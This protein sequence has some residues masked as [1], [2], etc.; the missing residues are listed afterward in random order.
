VSSILLVRHGPVALTAPGLLTRA[1]FLD[2]AEA[3]ERAGLSPDTL[4]PEGLVRRVQDAENVFVSPALRALESMKML[5]PRRKPFID[6][7]FSE[8]P[9]TVPELAGRWPLLVW[10]ALERATGAFHPGEAPSRL[11]MRQRAEKA[12]ALLIEATQ[13]GSTVLVGHGWFNRALAKALEQKGWRRSELQG[14]SWSLGRVSST[15]GM[16]HFERGALPK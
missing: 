9:H 5:D 8:Q 10:F 7:V 11:A 2:H 1:G 15:W 12:A 16:A 14:R 3:Y 4:A 6:P 13:R